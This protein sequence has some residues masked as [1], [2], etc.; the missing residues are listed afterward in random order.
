MGTYAGIQTRVRRRVIDAPAAVVAEVPTLVNEGYKAI[1]KQHN[2]KV[3]EK[4]AA[5]T[6]VVD[7]RAL[8]VQPTDFKEFHDT[9]RPYYLFNSGSVRP[10][11]LAGSKFGLLTGISEAASNSPRV[12][13]VPPLNV[14]GTGTWQLYPLPD[15]NSDY[16]DGEYRVK[17]PYYGYLSALS[18]DGDTNWLTDVGEEYI[19]MYA[20][21]EAFAVDWDED[22]MAI[23]AQKMQLKLQETIR[24]DKRLRLSG[25]QELVPFQGNNDPRT[26]E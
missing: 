24:L 4:L 12:L 15:G 11:Q 1:Q 23:W 5:F 17:V 2:F 9:D 6:T 3:M 21:M 16:G 18:A 7:T 14:D 20:V 19:V 22:R 26:R 8:G 13:Y 10:I 25:V